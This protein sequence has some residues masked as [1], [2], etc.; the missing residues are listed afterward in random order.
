MATQKR[1]NEIVRK[2]R[3]LAAARDQQ[4]QE[5]RAR[6][7]RMLQ[8]AKAARDAERS[9]PPS[10]PSN[11]GAVGLGAS[12]SEQELFVK[13]HDDEVRAKRDEMFA[14]RRQARRAS[15][16]A[17]VAARD[18]AAADKRD[19]LFQAR[20]QQR[21]HA[22]QSS[23]TPHDSVQPAQPPASRAQSPGRN[24]DDGERVVNFR[25]VGG[26]VRRWWLAVAG[27]GG[28]ACS[29][30]HV[31]INAVRR[32]NVW[33]PS[34]GRRPCQH[35]LRHKPTCL[36]TSWRASL[37]KTRSPVTH[38]LDTSTPHS[39]RPQPMPHTAP[40]TAAASS[41]CFRGPCVA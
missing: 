38:L 10:A 22:K 3:A 12:R 23:S 25:R 13:K 16:E 32:A 14:K 1:I 17:D 15:M 18:K 36:S 31:C 30:R 20:K 21:Q 19:A 9:Q 40:T 11:T 39:P 6:R 29:S 35:R 27:L 33:N 37:P 8:A 5:T 41:R 28:R 26:K 4:F 24:D 34:E 2:D 7:L